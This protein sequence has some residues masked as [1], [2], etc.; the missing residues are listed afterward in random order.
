VISLGGYPLRVSHR[1]Q[2]TLGEGSQA[3]PDHTPAKGHSWSLSTL[4][5]RQKTVEGPVEVLYTLIAGVNDRICHIYELANL[6]E[7][8]GSSVRFLRYHPDIGDLRHSPDLL[9]I[10][11]LQEMLTLRGIQNTYQHTRH[12]AAVECSLVEQASDVEVA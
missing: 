9:Y 6:L 2:N 7:G 3:Q 12:I 8:T 4:K 5:E 1:M 11:V 10:E